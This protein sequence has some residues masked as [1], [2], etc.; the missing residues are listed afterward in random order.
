MKEHSNPIAPNL[1]PGEV[2]PPA[3]EGKVPTRFY[4]EI[5]FVS[6]RGDD[7]KSY[8]NSPYTETQ[9]QELEGIRVA[10]TYLDI[11]LQ[12]VD[13]FFSVGV[14]KDESGNTVIQLSDGMQDYL[15]YEDFHH[16]EET[17]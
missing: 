4:G 12:N 17:E 8:G 2:M 5:V 10:K 6:A 3:P 1:R 15:D 14:S 11:A 9:V 7:D 13:D 16:E